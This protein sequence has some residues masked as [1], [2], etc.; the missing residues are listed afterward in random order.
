[1]LMSHIHIHLTQNERENWH[2]YH[3]YKS[4]QFNMTASRYMAQIYIVTIF[5]CQECNLYVHYSSETVFV[6]YRDDIIG[7]YDTVRWNI[8]YSGF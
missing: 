6:L 7:R 4:S 5:I 2:V 8:F 3:Y 1:M